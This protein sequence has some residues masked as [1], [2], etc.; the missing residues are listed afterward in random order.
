ML[1]RIAKRKDNARLPTVTKTIQLSATSSLERVEIDCHVET[2]SVVTD[3][4]IERREKEIELEGSI[5]IA[6]LIEM[7]VDMLQRQVVID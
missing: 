3:F 4:S 5:V 6:I 7:I 1:H 2:K